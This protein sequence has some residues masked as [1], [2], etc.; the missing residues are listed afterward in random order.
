MQ[1]LIAGQVDLLLDFPRTS[2]PLG[3][4]ESIK[5]YGVISDKR[6]ATA[7]DA[8]T[9][10]EMGVPALSYAERVG[11]FAPAGTPRDIVAKLNE[12]ALEA[13]AD[14][15]TQARITEFGAEIFPRQQQTPRALGELQKT[16]I[17]KW[18]LLIKE[19]ALHGFAP[20]CCRGAS[21]QTAPGATAYG[22]HE[23]R[24]EHGV[25]KLWKA[26]R[27]GGVCQAVRWGTLAKHAGGNPVRGSPLLDH[28]CAGRSA[29]EV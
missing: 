17:K 28:G 3:R 14:P 10:A 18:W 24:D 29:T 12:A 5:A 9:F 20:F 8:P 1:D 7:P 26:G 23:R 4:A 16:Q 6:L 2:L 25:G 15:A 27:C 19:F 11:L 22:V 21:R 13:L